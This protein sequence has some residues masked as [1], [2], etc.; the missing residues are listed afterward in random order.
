MKCTSCGTD[1]EAAHVRCMKCGHPLTIQK[2][3]VS[4]PANGFT[5]VALGITASDV[6]RKYKNEYSHVSIDQTDRS[7]ETIQDLLEMIS[8]KKVDSKAL[9]DHIA[10]TVYRQMHIKEVSVGLRSTS[11][12]KYR[13]ASMQGMR[14]NVWTEHQKLA[15][16]K[17]QF[18]DNSV[19]KGTTISK[20][21]KL[22]L[23]EDEP[24][25]ESEK[26]TFSEHL[27]QSSKRKAAGDS[28]EGDYLDIHVLGRG[29]ELLGW[30]EISGTWEGKLP[31]PR[32]LKTLEIMASLIGIAFSRDPQIIEQAP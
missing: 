26:G 32:T 27:S 23:A 11:D 13:Y 1:N 29:D 3:K 8:T 18:F 16:T 21:T 31:D 20:Y 24:Y 2:N 25:H 12:S 19:Y 14:A 17:D 30:I 7:I 22:L 4:G 28:I 15:Y 10:K 9:C 6:A 5:S